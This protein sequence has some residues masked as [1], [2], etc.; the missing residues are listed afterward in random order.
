MVELQL[1]ILDFLLLVRCSSKINNSVYH[2]FENIS[3]TT[4]SLMHKTS[5]LLHETSLSLS[6]QLERLVA[7][8]CVCDFSTYVYVFRFAKNLRITLIPL[9]KVGL[10]V[11][12]IFL[13]HK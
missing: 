3:P 11:S 1:K 4:T 10:C 7:G 9:S 5:R 13:V 12:R 6:S 8:V 2:T